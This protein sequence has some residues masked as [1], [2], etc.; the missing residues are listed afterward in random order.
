[1]TALVALAALYP[2]QPAQQWH[3]SLDWQPIPYD[4]L[5]AEKDDVRLYIIFETIIVNDSVHSEGIFKI[6]LYIF[7]GF[8]AFGKD[9]P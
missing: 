8:F 6:I 5:P 1:M 4:T 7:S 9:Y 3:P 2:P